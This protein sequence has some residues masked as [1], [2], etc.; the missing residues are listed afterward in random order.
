[1]LYPFLLRD[2]LLSLAEANLYEVR[3]SERILDEVERNLVADE[4]ITTDQASRLRAVMAEH[5]EGAAVPQAKVDALE[6]TMTNDP[7]DRHV[8]A[9]AVVARADDVV[10][11]NLRDF[12]A[13][14][15]RAVD[16]E[17]RHPD[18]FLSDLYR[19]D[20]RTVY[21]TI[22]GQAQRFSRP[23]I[24]F[25]ELLDRLAVTTPQFAETL[26]RHR[27]AVREPP[28]RPIAVEPVRP[29]ERR[30][31]APVTARDRGHSR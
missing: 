1:M 26:R 3:W 2:T 5:F 24:E 23:P 29:A 20:P 13:R 7:K 4:R 31:A 8:L 22:Q 25:D 14:A 21:A 11:L 28:G 17:P 6:P 30:A 19:R 18:D 12:P 27:D 15:C 10:T 9:A 16:I